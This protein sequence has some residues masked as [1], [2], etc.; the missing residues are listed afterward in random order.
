MYSTNVVYEVEFD[1]LDD[2]RERFDAWV[3]TGIIEWVGHESVAAFEVLTGGRRAST[4]SK[5]VFEFETLRDWAAFVESDRHGDAVERLEGL[6]ENREATLWRRASVN[7]DVA[8]D[9]TASERTDG[10]R[11]GH[12]T[13]TR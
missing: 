2:R 11:D 9:R 5:F 13:S 8:L 1:V 7:L 12:A 4:D 6:A 10:G 3:A